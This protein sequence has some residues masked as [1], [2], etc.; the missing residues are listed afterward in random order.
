MLVTLSEAVCEGP[1]FCLSVTSQLPAL[2]QLGRTF[3]SSQTLLSWPH[4]GLEA[5]CK[6]FI[7]PQQSLLPSL[8]LLQLITAKQITCP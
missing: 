5:L 3:H 1:L 4:N 8:D 7:F 6:L 2:S